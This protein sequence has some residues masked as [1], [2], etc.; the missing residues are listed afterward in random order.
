[1][2]DKIVISVI[3]GAVLD[4]AFGDPALVCHP[5]R[6]IGK[7]TEKSE[8]CLRR[9]FPETKKGERA[10][11]AVMTAAV[12]AVSTAVPAAVLHISGKAN[13]SAALAAEA[14]MCFR[15]L[16]AKSLRDES[17]TVC[18]ALR[19]GDVSEARRAVSMIVGR[20]TDALDEKG[21]TK[22]AV[23][24]VAEN[25]SDGVV[26]PLFYMMIAGAPGGFF[27]KAVNT[28]DSMVGYENDRYRYFGT[29]SARLDDIVNFIP[30]RLTAVCMTAAAYITGADAENAVYIYKRD[31]GKHASPNSG[32]TESVMAGALDI[33]LAGDAVYFGKVHKKEKIGDPVR[34]IEPD[35]IKKANEIMN[36]TEITAIAVMSSVRILL[37]HIFSKKDERRK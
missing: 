32:Q 10:A 3:T 12:A 28:M 6:A 31:R 36:V 21:I 15:M 26:A 18:S 25:T 1:M 11:G 19:K 17:M 2:K 7:L 8:Y 33:E 13:R 24:T 23:E 9:V 34:E 30:A 5:V 22:A 16:A 14:F 20:D 27:Y 37:R 4:L 35:D 29:C